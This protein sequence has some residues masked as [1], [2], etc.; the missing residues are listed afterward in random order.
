MYGTYT[1]Y[2]SL[3]GLILVDGELLKIDGL[4]SPSR[5]KST[6]TT[7]KAFSLFTGSISKQKYTWGT[8]HKFCEKSKSTIG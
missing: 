2:P 8:S 1:V 5:L 7:T 6:D 4:M 3:D